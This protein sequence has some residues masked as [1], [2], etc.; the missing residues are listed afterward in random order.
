M[1]LFR[2][3]LLFF[4]TL[5]VTYGQQ[6]SPEVQRLEQQRKEALAEIEMTN[7]LLR[8]TE[9]TTKNYLNRLNLLGNQILQRKK[10]IS[11]LV[12]ETA[13][14][15]REIK[16]LSNE[17]NLLEKELKQKQDNYKQSAQRLQRRANSQ[18]KLLFVLSAD[19]FSQSM[20]RM[21]YLREFAYWQ[22]QQAQTIVAKQKEITAKQ[23]ELQKTRSE[24]QNLLNEREEENKK[25]VAEEAGQK[26]EV[27]QLNK[28]QKELQAQLKQ[29]KQRA[30]A[31]NQQ[32]EKQIAEEIAR[33]E[34]AAKAQAAGTEPDRIAD[35]KGGY[36]MTKAEKQL[37]D[38]FAGN[39][40]RLPFPLEGQYAIV[41][42]F[43]EQ[44][45]AELKYVR[46]NNSGIDIQTTPGTDARAVFNGEVTRVFVV[47]GYNNSVIVRHGN[48]LTVYSN[49]SQV[50]VKAGDKV[51]TR[52]PIGRIFSDNENANE[53][54]L[55]FQLWKEKTKLNPSPWLDK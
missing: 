41:G 16:S 38:D 46:M 24:K 4:F 45:H 40:G 11:L 30:Q 29:K 20:R 3:I 1:R 54:I 39:R 13:A 7:K 28:R 48:Y 51:K 35:S 37:S 49:L 55:H 27:Q 19:N 47:P 33:A 23:E 17:I 22:K 10:V 53:T 34:A 15:D 31:L 32:I 26:K 52:Q 2:I 9:S 8:E 5:Q 42:T 21:R 44:Q 14:I 36:A 18:D 43:G 12:Q 50:Y 6:K 25:L